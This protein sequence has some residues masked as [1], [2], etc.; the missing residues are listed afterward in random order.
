MSIIEINK[1]DA[2]TARLKIISDAL[3][4]EEIRESD[5]GHRFTIIGGE[6]IDLDDKPEPTE[7]IPF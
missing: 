3:E 1:V 2:L 4:A 5:C 6:V 7:E